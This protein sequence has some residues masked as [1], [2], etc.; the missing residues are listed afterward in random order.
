MRVS[1]LIR[2]QLPLARTA[3]A[4]RRLVHGRPARGLVAMFHIGRCGSTVLAELLAQHPALAWGG[5]LFDDVRAVTPGY[6]PDPDWVRT[7][8]AL[9]AHR[10]VRDYFGFETKAIHFTSD[11]LGMTVDSYVQLLEQM[12]VRH[13]IVLG[14]RNLLRVVVSSLI[15][16]EKRSWH[17]AAASPQP[18]R[19][20]LD[21]ANPWGN[22]AGSLLE[23][24]EAYERFYQMLEASLSARRR[25]ELSYETD[26]QENPA[27]A[28]GKVCD[29]L[30]IA[31]VPVKVALARTNPFKLPDMLAN[32]AAVE[33]ALRGTRFAW[34]LEG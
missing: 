2:S 18:T 26:I 32:H 28:Y 11:C 21:I 3:A 10:N 24:F 16:H 25:L 27:I 5:E 13:F 31:P 22:G 34:M 30:Q 17:A 12:D 23:T 20:H 4:L 19:I 6:R 14:R 8:I 1:R 29:F 15:G 9:A 33:Q 7:V